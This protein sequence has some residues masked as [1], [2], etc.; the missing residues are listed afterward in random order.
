[1]ASVRADQRLGAIPTQRESLAAGAP[2][3]TG[4]DAPADTVTAQAGTE[5]ATGFVPAPAAAPAIETLAPVR[6][7]VDAPEPGAATATRTP[8][9]D[10]PAAPVLEPVRTAEPVEAPAPVEPTHRLRTALVAGAVTI[11][12]AGL[13]TG[14]VVKVQLDARAAELARAQARVELE[15]Q[16]RA[17]DS[18]F[19]A[20]RSLAAEAAT[21]ASFRAGALAQAAAVTSAAQGALTAT[22]QAGDAPRAALQAAIDA[23]T[24]VT[25]TTGSGTNVATLRATAVGVAAP[26][27]AAVDAQAAWQV[28]ED[29]R[30]AAEKAAAEQAAAEAAQAAARRASTRSPARTTTSRPATSSGG[31]AAAA[32]APA[33][34]AGGWVP[35]VEAFGVGGLGAEINAHRAANGLPALSVSGSSSMQNHAAD[36]AA[37]WSIWHSGR[38]HIV[39]YVQPASAGSMIQAYA[40]SP[41]HNAWLLSDSSHVSIGAVTLNGRLFTAMVFS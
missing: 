7:P 3:A 35:G 13:T 27:Q 29:A 2:P 38:D 15:S 31:A 10:P 22:P 20:G 21:A 4:A 6:P 14:I 30:I 32:P 16:A 1:M 18:E 37:A 34:E 8:V 40:N 9:A 25:A 24:A 23:V 12:L 36:M 39:G 11:V 19:L 33:E 5:V 26:Q 28:A 17:V 41:G